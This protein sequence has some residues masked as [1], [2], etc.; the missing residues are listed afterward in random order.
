MA[1]CAPSLPLH[2]GKE[3]DRTA[4]GHLSAEE[5]ASPPGGAVG[6]GRL[7]KGGPPCLGKPPPSPH[8]PTSPQT[9]SAPTPGPNTGIQ[10]FAIPPSFAS[11]F[12]T[13]SAKLSCLVTNLATYDSLAI[14]W[15]GQDGKPLKTHTNISES[16]PNTTF[17]ATGEATI[18][19]EDW[20]SGD[21]FTCT[22]THTDL[23][24]PRKQTVS[25]PKGRPCLPLPS[26]PDSPAAS[27]L[28]A[29]GRGAA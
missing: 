18:C 6:S 11:I 20:E 14:S 8:F 23:P 27:G 28:L 12:L 2:S 24:S 3:R 9:C 1:R 22:V 21:E 19:V 26:A 13:K 10:V 15:T 7:S 25:R 29:A 4:W 5:P 16:H 17:S